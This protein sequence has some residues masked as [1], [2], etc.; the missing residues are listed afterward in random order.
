MTNAAYALYLEDRVLSADPMELVRL[1][2]QGCIDAVSEARQQLAD[3]DIVERSRAISKAYDILLE[4]ATSL[5]RRR[6]GEIGE[7]LLSLYEYMRRRLIEANSRQEDS[8][9]A[10]VLG[11]LETLGEAWTGVEERLREEVSAA[12]VAHAW[13]L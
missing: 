4:L 2:Y 9:L 11:I 10:E 12:P 8:P 3:G 6:G 5:D 13:S 1:L 7:R